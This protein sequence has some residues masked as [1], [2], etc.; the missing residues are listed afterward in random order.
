MPQ[1]P[2]ARITDKVVHPLPGVLVGSPGSVNVMIGSLPAWRGL[3]LAAVAGLQSAQSTALATA[4]SAEAA[5]VAAAAT[6][7]GPAARAAAEA[8]K[9]AL[10]ASMSS[11]ISA[12]AAGGTDI[13]TCTTIPLAPGHGPGV[14]ITGSAT[15]MINNMPACRLGDQILE[16]LGPPDFIV[17][18]EFTV[19]IGG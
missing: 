4:M 14:V 9:A 13:H 10:L 15:V 6:P 19:I 8:T 18:G 16:A 17:K 3:P 11:A 1:G 7:G 12:A 5:A 2:A